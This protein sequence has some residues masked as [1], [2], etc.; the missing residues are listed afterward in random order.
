MIPVDVHPYNYVMRAFV[1]NNPQA[2]PVAL[3]TGIPGKRL[4][5]KSIATGLQ[6]LRPEFQYVATSLSYWASSDYQSYDSDTVSRK[7][8]SATVRLEGLLDAL[9]ICSLEEGV[10]PRSGMSFKNTPFENHDLKV[11]QEQVKALRSPSE[12][13]VTTYA[14]FWTIADFWKHYLPCLPYPL[15]FERSG[16]IDFQVHLGSNCSGP[17]LADL[18]IPTFN[19]ACSLVELVGRHMGAPEDEWSVEKLEW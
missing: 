6:H 1:R 14:D 2:K 5:L 16:V 10:S 18:I 12:R 3:A 4:H 17:L 9:V 7:L 15:R 19:H 13:S 8:T 11:I